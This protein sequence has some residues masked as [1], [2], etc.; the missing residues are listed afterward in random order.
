MVVLNFFKIRNILW[1]PI[2]EYVIYLFNGDK[3]CFAVEGEK[4]LRSI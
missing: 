3:L 1:K 2:Y 4:N